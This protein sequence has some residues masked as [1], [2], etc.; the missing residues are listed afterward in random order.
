[1]E[2]NGGT[3]LRMDGVRVKIIIM[4]IISGDVGVCEGKHNGW[5]D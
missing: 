3:E 1:M 5:M 2:K 4:I